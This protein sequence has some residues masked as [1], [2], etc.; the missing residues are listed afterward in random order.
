MPQTYQIQG[1]RKATGE[2][3]AQPIIIEAASEDAAINLIS[4][5]GILVSDCRPVTTATGAPQSPQKI[6]TERAMAKE[7]ENEIARGVAKGIARVI[8]WVF[9]GLV[10]L[11]IA[12]HAARM[13][14]DYWR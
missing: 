2:P 11:G 5:R 4:A 13:I 10:L 7:R 1:V 12:P 14:V 3:T 6:E 9:V 8:L